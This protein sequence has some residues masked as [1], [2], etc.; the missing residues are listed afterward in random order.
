MELV[1]QELHKL[2]TGRVP[3]PTSLAVTP[4]MK[5]ASDARIRVGPKTR[6][7]VV[8][9][10]AAVY[11]LPCQLTEKDALLYRALLHATVRA[12]VDRT[13]TVDSIDS[14]DPGGDS[15]PPWYRSGLTQT[16][17]DLRCARV[18]PL[19]QLLGRRL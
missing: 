12:T 10:Q 17:E 4:R 13:S 2:P 18:G 14:G 6:G 8:D 5:W 19:H 15:T 3:I 11:K 1:R 9:D 16:D 7:E